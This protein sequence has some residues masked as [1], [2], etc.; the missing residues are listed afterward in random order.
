[1]GDGRIRIKRHAKMIKVHRVELKPNNKQ[2]TYFVKACGV[3]RF[4]YN[5]ALAEWQEAYKRGDKVSEASLRKA[6]NAC[7]RIE[8]PW[9]LEVTKNSPQQAIKNLGTAFKR[10]FQK[11]GG[12]PKF[13]KKGVHDSFRADNGPPQKGMDAVV[14]EG[15]YIYLSVI[16]KVK[17]K[18]KIRCSGQIKS[19]TI[20]REASKW[21]AAIGIDVQEET[22]VRKSHGTVGVD[23][24]IK[25]LA[26]LSDGTIIEGPK[27][28][29]RSLQRLR[30]KSR[31]LSKRKRGSKN[32]GKS[33]QIL[34]RHHARIKNIR[35]DCMH[36]LT[37]S[38]VTKYDKICIEDLNV[39]GMASNRRLSRS[40]M[41]QGFYEFRRQL[42]YKGEWYRAKVYIADRYYPSSKLC[43]SCGEKNIDLKLGDRT[44]QCICGESH[45][46]DENAAKNLAKLIGTVSSTGTVTRVTKACGE[47][48]AGILAV[49]NM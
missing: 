15:K 49:A 23:L 47:E 19:V 32:Y 20:V 34:A 4:A 44:W 14:V 3:A 1:M 38:L 35:L 5:W 6:L 37:T 45:N 10:F 29:S 31:K 42:T 24:G 18:E 7:K 25:D 41:D 46:R 28:Y 11:K 48:S 40:I 30:R 8:Y 26:T 22:Y 12:Y 16:G 39:R 43:S 17:L 9:M 36:K 27:S 21:Y 33:K 2:K 13:K